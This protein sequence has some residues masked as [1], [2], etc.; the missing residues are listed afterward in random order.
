MPVEEE[1]ASHH[2]SPQL[3]VLVP[4]EVAGPCNRLIF[5]KQTLSPSL[6]ATSFTIPSRRIST[7]L[8]V[9]LQMP[10]P[11]KFKFPS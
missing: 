1:V 11:R 4:E 8:L 2:V 7:D 9:I 6:E 3:A 10:R 5:T